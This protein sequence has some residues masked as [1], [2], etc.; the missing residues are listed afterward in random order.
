VGYRL[1]LGMTFGSAT[2]TAPT[3]TAFVTPD[4]PTAFSKAVSAPDGWPLM[5]L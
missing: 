2:E 3:P 1:A 5:E 4:V